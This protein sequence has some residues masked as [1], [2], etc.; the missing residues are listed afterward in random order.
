MNKQTNKQTTLKHF[1]K[2]I[3]GV[4]FLSSLLYCKDDFTELQSEESLKINHS[5][6]AREINGDSLILDNPY[7]VENMLAA[8]ENI[9]NEN[10][11]FS[12]KDFVIK[13]SHVYLKFT[14]QNEEEVGLLKSDSTIHYFDYRLDCEYREG[15]LD[16]RIP[17]SDSISV[18]YTAVPIDKILP[19]VSHEIISELYIPEQDS[20]FDDVMDIEKYPVPNRVT[21]SKTDLFYNLL[22][23]AFSQTGNEDDILTDDSTSTSKWIFGTKWYPSGRI[24][25]SDDIAGNVPVTGAQVLM[26][27]WFTVRQGITDNGGYF[28]TGFVRG[29]ARYVLQWERYNYSVRD[30]SF[31]QAETHGP[32]VKQQSWNKILN[33]GK[34]EYHAI[35]HQAA[36]DYYYGNRFGLISPPMNQHIYSFGKQSQIKI[37]GRLT[38]SGP[39]SSYSHIRSDVT[40]GL[41]AQVHIKD[42][43]KPS[44]QV[45]G[46]TIH[47]LSHALHS[48]K[49]RAS[50]DNIVRDSF[51]SGNSQV[52]KR[53]RRLLESWP[54]AVETLM[55]LE[56]YRVRFN[57]PIY[58][59]YSSLNIVNYQYRTIV[60]ENLYTSGIYDMT[61]TVNQRRVYGSGYPMDM[62]NGY[63]IKELENAL[64]GAR[65]WND[66]R[67]KVKAMYPNKPTRPYVD[68][69]FANWQD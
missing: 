65:Y 31:F 27:Q 30:G 20:Y 17:D 59:V 28:N 16:T 13:P 41:S 7:S 3:L 50:Y 39:S 12:V 48:V 61:D 62:V 35:I 52:R 36:H 47:E 6:S 26:R 67:D 34:D 44:D 19:E 60:E 22:Y 51:L 64:S 55:T 21:D 63:T 42:Y 11:D 15:F 18:Y 68:E 1:L 53:N 54:I 40:F 23:N 32:N 43:G 14:P 45:Y 9:K 10:P 29:K 58:N 57:N 8:L 24:L 69:L 49:D 5:Y 2:Y 37:A 4:M 66:Y 25:V 56:R 33:G 38:N 46:T